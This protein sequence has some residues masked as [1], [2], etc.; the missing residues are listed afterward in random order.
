MG[1]DSSML[2]FDYKFLT[3]KGYTN[4]EGK[5]VSADDEAT[6]KASTW[7]S[8]GYRVIRWYVKDNGTNHL[9]LEKQYRR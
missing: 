6:E 4:S 7:G 3:C 5:A 1:Y 2:K 9:V 8:K